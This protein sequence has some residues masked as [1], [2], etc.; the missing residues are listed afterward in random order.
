M[1]QRYDKA[2]IQDYA[3]TPEGYLTV[4]APITR[5]GVFPYMHED[6]ILMEAKLPEDL[7]STATVKSANAKPITDEHPNGIVTLANHDKY[8]KGMTHT[9]ATVKDHKLYVSFT[10][11]DADTIQKVKNGK[12]ELSIGF[13]ADIEKS[14]G[15]YDGAKYDAVQRN[16]Q[17]NHVAL[18]DKGRAG[19]SVAIR[20]DAAVM[21]DADADA[22]ADVKQNK[23]GQT[24]PTL[25]LDNI[26][27]E[28][29]ATVKAKFE[30][31]ETKLD[32]AETKAKQFDTLKGNHD[33]LVTQLADKEAELV[34][35]K[36]KSDGLDDAVN[37]RVELISNTKQ[38]LGDAFEFKGKSDR[39]IKVAVI[40]TT[41]KD[42]KGDG[43][44]DEYINGRYE[45]LTK[46]VERKGFTQSVVFGDSSGSEI[47]QMRAS[48][49]NMKGV[50]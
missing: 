44:S 48:R 35:V 9:D 10:I 47:D 36:Q 21:V 26:E 5:P 30:T 17:I 1:K 11:T 14:V 46:V 15:L 43:L 19:P 24:M 50:K 12:R 37:A 28:V 23:G 25:K 4:T 16:M 13:L 6:G 8:A 2:L 29:D 49:L 22:D 33:A 38:I 45:G 20:G 39:D 32:A 3:E 18:V 27:Y 7:F 31:L 42:F 41:E 34:E 40:A